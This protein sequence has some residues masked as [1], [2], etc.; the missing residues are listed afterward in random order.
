MFGLKL[1][2]RVDENS[3]A[4]VKMPPP[5]VLRVQPDSFV[6]LET[7]EELRAWE[8]AVQVSTGINV[9]APEGRCCTISCSAGCC[10]DSDLA[11][12]E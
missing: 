11:R 3:D 7:P 6:R 10:D 8:S 9:P 2:D 1:G 4:F 5:V 12:L